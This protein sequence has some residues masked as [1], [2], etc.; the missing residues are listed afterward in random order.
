M[1]LTDF[2]IHIIVTII[3]QISIKNHHDFFFMMIY[4]RG[5]RLRTLGLR[6]W[7]PPLYQLSYSPLSILSHLWWT[8]RDSNPGPTGYEPAALPTELTVQLY[9]IAVTA[10][11]LFHLAPPVGL[12]PTT[13]RLTAACSTYWAKEASKDSLLSLLCWHWPIF[14]VRRQTSIFGTDELNFCVRNGNRWTLIVK[15]TNYQIHH[16][17]LEPW[18]PW[19]RVRCSTSWAN[20]AYHDPRESRTPDWGVRGPRLDHLTIGPFQ[21]PENWVEDEARQNLH[22]QNVG[23]ALGLLVPVSW[24]HYC[25]YTSGLSTK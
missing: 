14:P 24:M 11:R 13:P 16:Q 17:G 25:T 18:T 2:H 23:Q 8:V 15:S 1:S 19:L 7:R 12:E 9:E 6:F 10:W 3:L 4:S 5:R 21:H 20:G 22:N